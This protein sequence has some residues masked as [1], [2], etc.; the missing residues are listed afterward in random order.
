MTSSN[1][2]LRFQFKG[3]RSYVHGT[4]IYSKLNEVALKDEG[5]YLARLKIVNMLKSNAILSWALANDSQT[6]S[7]T[8]LCAIGEVH[9][10]TGKSKLFQIFPDANSKIIDRHEYPEGVIISKLIVD[11]KVA[12]LKDLTGFTLI[13]E[14]VASIK[15]LSNIIAPPK[16]G[17]WLFAGLQLKEQMPAM[18]NYGQVLKVMQ[19]Q[20]IANRFSRNDIYLDDRMYGTIEFSV[21]DA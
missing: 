5:A 21:G 14:A 10:K 15:N 18:R 2:F 12:S 8:C 19:R 4:D 13:E 9:L 7:E 16:T 6:A 3:D 11:C 17:K 1:D 20:M